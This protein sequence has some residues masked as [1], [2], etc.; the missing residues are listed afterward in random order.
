[1]N[2]TKEA[3]GQA[4]DLRATQPINFVTRDDPPAILV[5]GAD[6]TTVA[7]KHTLHLADLLQAK[8]VI[9]ETRVYRG[10]GHVGVMLAVAG[11]FRRRA[12][13]LRDVTDFLA[14]QASEPPSAARA[15]PPSA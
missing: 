2:S 13:V 12:P 10:V 8:G 11:P 6:D 14:K 15:Q 7:P 1:V 4:Q 9:A 5:T 3:F